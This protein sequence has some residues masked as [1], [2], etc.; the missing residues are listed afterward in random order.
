MLVVAM[1]PPLFPVSRL[2]TPSIV[3][4]LEFGRCPLAVKP[5]ASSGGPL[6]RLPPLPGWGTTPGTRVTKP[7]RERP[8]LAMFSMVL[9]SSAY[10]RSPLAACSSLTRPVTLTCSATTP[11]SSVRTPAKNLSLAFTTTFVRS[12]VLKPSRLTRSE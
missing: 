12:S 7:K 11:T 10:E 6:I 4:L 5:L 3:M 1:K 8:L 2:P 9:F